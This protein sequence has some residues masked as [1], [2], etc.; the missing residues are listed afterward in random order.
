MFQTLFLHALLP[1]RMLQ[2]EDFLGGVS[3]IPMQGN[4]TTPVTTH[5]GR[6]DGGLLSTLSSYLMSPTDSAQ[7]IVPEVADRDIEHTMSAIDCIGACRLDELYTQIA[8]VQIFWLASYLSD[9]TSP[10]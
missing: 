3:T 4:A 1:S 5:P 6:P 7:A 8:S 10:Q 2:S 9:L